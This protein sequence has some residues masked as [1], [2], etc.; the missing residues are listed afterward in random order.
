MTFELQLD[1]RNRSPLPAL[2]LLRV[3]VRSAAILGA[4]G[5]ANPI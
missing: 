4:D 2:P 5:K 1:A 3:H